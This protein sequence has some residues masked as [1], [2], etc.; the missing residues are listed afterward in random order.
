MKPASHTLPWGR[1]ISD[2]PL[3]AGQ[4]ISG[5][6]QVPLIPRS[7]RIKLQDGRVA[8]DRSLVQRRN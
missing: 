2:Y 8:L 5:G 6:L 1:A 7:L 4:E 3:T